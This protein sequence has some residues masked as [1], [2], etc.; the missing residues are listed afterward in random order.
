MNIRLCIF[1]LTIF[2]FGTAFSQQIFVLPKDGHTQET[3]SVYFKWNPNIYSDSYI[4]QVATDTTFMGNS[5]I[6]SVLAY[7]NF[8]TYDF[9]N[10]GIFYCRVKGRTEQTWS[11]FIKIELLNLNNDNNLI[12]WFDAGKNISTNDS[13]IPQWGDRKITDRIARQ[14]IPSNQ[15]V[16]SAPVKL[17]NNKNTISFNGNS[18]IPQYFNLNMPIDF[19]THTLFTVRN[20][21]P[22]TNL[23][24]YYLSGNANGLFSESAAG[25]VGYGTFDLSGKL[26]A[27]ARTALTPDF[28]IYT[29]TNNAQ[30][31]NNQF[32][33]NSQG[34]T[35]MDACNLTTIGTRPDARILAYKGAI[36]EILVFDSIINPNKRTTVFNY[37]KTK[38]AP[39]VN[40]DIDTVA[41]TSFADSITLTVVDRFKKYVWSN[42][43]STPTTKVVTSRTYKLKTIDIFGF[44][45]EDE[46]DVYPY[47]RLKKAKINL[48]PGE[49]INVNTGLDNSYT[50]L[51]S[52]GMTTNSILINSPGQYTVKITKGSRTVNDTIIVSTTAIDKTP[53]V[54]LPAKQANNVLNVCSGQKV[55][56]KNDSTF[57]SLMWSTGSITNSETI[58]YSDQVYVHYIEKNGC[59][60]TDTLNIT[61]SG[62]AP[63]ADFDISP[64]CV[65]SETLFS[66][67]SAVPSGNTIQSW[68]WNFSNGITSTQQYPSL[69]FSSI[70]IASASL[71]ITTN[72][73]CSD[74]IYKSF[75]VNKK[76]Q[77]SFYNLLSCSRYPTT[78]VDQTIINAPTITN[79]S[80]NFGGL[81]TSDGVKNPNFIFPNDGTYNISLKVTNSN[82]C[83]D[84]ITLPTT[85]KATPFSNFSF[86]SVCGKN[87]VN[88]K[89]LGTVQPPN[90]IPEINWGRWDFGD[91]YFEN[92]VKSPK[93]TYSESGT[94]DVKLIVNS[95]NQ[96][97]DTITKKVTSYNYPV[98]DFTAS[99]TQC[100]GKEIQFTDISTSSDGTPITNWNWYFSGQATSVSQNPK[101]TF[102]AQGN[103][104]IQLT[105][106]NSVGCSATKLRSIAV[107]TPPIPKFTFSPQN[108]LPPLNVVYTNQ[109]PVTGNYIWNY[110]D[111]SPLVQAYNPPQHIYTTKGTY[112]IQLIATDFR[113]CTDTLTKYI[114]VDK[115]YVDGVMATISIT[116]NGDFYKIQ[117]TVINNSNIEITS[118]G[119]SLQ[120]G[121]GAVIRE[122]WTGSLLPGQT[123][124][125]M[126]TGEIKIGENGQ[127]PV[128][129]ASIE[130]INNNTPEDRTDNN[131]TCKEV[132]VGSFN[133]LN[134]YPNPAN[135]NINFGVM[136]PKDG[137]V[138][139]R[140]IDIIGQGLYNKDFNG[141]RGYNQFTMPVST[142]NSAVY[143][144]EI[145]FDGETVREK[146]MI[147]NK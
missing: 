66:D 5:R 84:T 33:N 26:L 110:G 132:A 52:N 29:S 100:V 111:G 28:S 6:A 16:Q 54:Y 68:N 91:G 125:Y 14:E 67:A 77:P 9:A 143:I 126:F 74:S 124:V 34:A 24:Q 136:L 69:P 17:L 43:D 108:G 15:P 89:F 64:V 105:A 61:V 22:S 103:Y 11:P 8:Y 109:S 39:P 59:K 90:V 45:S 118:M 49:S 70:G 97:A 147:K 58:H 115:A 37:L 119:L 1:T 53:I 7:S 113:G 40:L 36:A 38:Y 83:S 2:C 146:F 57:Q 50:F 65:N 140:F 51:W 138:N 128:V 47:R 145:S 92:A 137:K 99:Q 41:G 71:K 12:S 76:P 120:L 144:A 20:Y 19:T 112:P 107:S 18:T 3:K 106:K 122:N 79:W 131:T 44:E 75:M 121:G 96:C 130:N 82:G 129:C 10:Y 4:L 142:L 85:V 46:I 98:V 56:I 62:Q 73:G 87:P 134:I 94:Y 80:W 141:S 102:N 117:A 116:P 81:G 55:F 139:V 30:Y 31:R 88:F 114:L 60:L 72:I 93:H 42:G 104:T 32:V 123:T 13:F 27:A 63:T 21:Q 101:Y 35:T 78:F 127:I 133:I 25:G 23:V 95:T 86:D 48:C 135:D